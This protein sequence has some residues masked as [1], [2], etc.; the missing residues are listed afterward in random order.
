[1]FW[2]KRACFHVYV[3]IFK[4]Y[5]F[6]MFENSVIFRIHPKNKQLPKSVPFSLGT[7]H[8]AGKANWFVC[9]ALMN[10]WGHLIKIWMLHFY[11]FPVLMNFFF[12]H[13]VLSLFDE[14]SVILEGKR[15]ASRNGLDKSLFGLGRIFGLKYWKVYF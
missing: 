3:Y 4:Y 14:C 13:R 8:R 5:L 1:M 9:L 15:G 11:K 7:H 12:M 6:N 10:F 2:H